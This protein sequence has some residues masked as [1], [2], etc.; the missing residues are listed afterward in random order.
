MGPTCMKED[1]IMSKK[2]HNNSGCK[3][4]EP[5][6]NVHHRLPKSRGGSNDN[7]NL[8]YVEVEKHQ[9]YNLLF[10]SNPTAE[11]VVAVLTAIW[12]DPS[13]EITVAKKVQ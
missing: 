7:S 8:S 11:E 2:R 3:W 4:C 6:Y 5:K 10:G 9:A 1:K 12:I 13:Y